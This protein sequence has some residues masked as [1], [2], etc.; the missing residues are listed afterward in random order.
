V[1]G[2]IYYWQETLICLLQLSIPP[3][4]CIACLCNHSV[5]QFQ[6]WVYGNSFE[7]FLIAVA[8]PNQQALEH[9]AQEHGI[10]GNFKSLCENPEAKKFILG[11]LTKTGKEKKV[12]T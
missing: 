4:T 5:F 11:E 8:N 6:I 12:P 3:R 2:L 1:I 10:S 7:S 9:W